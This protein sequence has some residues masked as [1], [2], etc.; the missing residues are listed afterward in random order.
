MIKYKTMIHKEQSKLPVITHKSEMQKKKMADINEIAPVKPLFEGAIKTEKKDVLNKKLIVE[1]FAE[2][3]GDDGKFGVIVFT[4]DG[5]KKSTAISS[6]LLD[7][8]VE[9]SLKVGLNEETT[10][11]KE[12]FLANSFEVVIVEKQSTKNPNR[13]Y[14]DF[15]SE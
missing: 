11:A 3:E 7:R 15:K 8:I 6:M 4:H 9:A 14:F 5:V 12:K 13:T 2:L 1:G 10:T